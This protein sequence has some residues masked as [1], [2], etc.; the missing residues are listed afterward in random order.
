MPGRILVV[1]DSPTDQQA[2]RRPLE[3]S[4]YQVVSAANGVEARQMLERDT[5]DVIL[6]DVIMP[7]Q[8][9]FQLCRELRRDSRF[10]KMPIIMVTSKDQPADRFWGMKQGATEY[11]TKPFNA[12]ELVEVVR[13]H[14]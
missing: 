8:N 13:K 14:A 1:D 11:I 3:S 2:M 9:G 12:G 4:G 7:E 6:L 10:E 5:F